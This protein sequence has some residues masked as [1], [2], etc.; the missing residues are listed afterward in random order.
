ME[1]GCFNKIV[2]LPA[3]LITSISLPRTYCNCTSKIVISLLCL[4]SNS[5]CLTATLLVVVYSWTTGS[6][7]FHINMKISCLLDFP[8][9][10]NSIKNVTIWNW[11]NSDCGK[12]FNV[13]SGRRKKK[14]HKWDNRDVERVENVQWSLLITG[15][16]L[17]RHT[18]FKWST[19]GRADRIDQACWSRKTRLS[20]PKEQL[21]QSKMQAA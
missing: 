1:C 7:R 13:S 11:R 18:W 17:T 21:Y 5:L 16:S 14:T 12:W 6:P 20:S 15:V 19:G 10:G 2:N 4:R 9:R 8:R 3:L